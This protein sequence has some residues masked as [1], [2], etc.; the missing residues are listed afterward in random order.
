MG[1]NSKARGREVNGVLL[2]DKPAGATS[3]EVLQKVKSLYTAKKAGHTGSLDKA[4]S[5]LLPICFGEATK[6]SRFLLDADK[7][8]RAVCRLGIQT[9]TADAEG[10]VIEERPAPQLSR[11]EIESTLDQFKG[12]TWQTPPMFSALKHKGQRLYKLAYQGMEV[13]RR[14]RRIMLYRIALLR[15]SDAEFE[16]EV[17]CSKGTYIRTLA[18]DIGK[19]LGCGAH[20]KRLRRMGAGPFTHEKMLTLDALQRMAES[21]FI[22]LDREL[23]HIDSVL[24]DL[25]AI[26]LAQSVS[27][28][29]CQGQAVMVPHAP[30]R[31]MLRM[32]TENH[33]FIGIGEVLDDG[34]IAPKRLL[35]QY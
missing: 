14:P 4:A 2:L 17:A 34:R 16:I 19:A 28:Y 21:G 9:T 7:H 15:F 1:K 35:A 31:G 5:G 30:A 32:Y 3:N 33:R 13:D 6:F 23:L 18:E 24:Q 20:V 26:N 8:Y 12:E 11:R 10:E 25:P 27:H 22:K 29:L